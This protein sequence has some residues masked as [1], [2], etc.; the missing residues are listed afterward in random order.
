MVGL[1]VYVTAGSK[2][3]DGFIYPFSGYGSRVF[4]GTFCSR[5]YI[6]DTSNRL[7][8]LL[9]MSFLGRDLFPIRHKLVIKLFLLP[10]K[11]LYVVEFFLKELDSLLRRMIHN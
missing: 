11:L 7:E 3:D 4:F 6:Q 5:F 1:F 9:V 10:V 2:S 8:R